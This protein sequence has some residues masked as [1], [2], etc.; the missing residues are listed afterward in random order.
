MLVFD[1]L[2]WHLFNRHFL[3]DIWRQPDHH[4]DPGHHQGRVVGHP[5]VGRVVEAAR[6]DAEED[7]VLTD[8]LLRCHAGRENHQQVLQGH[9][10]A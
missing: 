8:V 9:G 1:Q 4:G 7:S 5:A 2:T 3:A 10:R 6:H